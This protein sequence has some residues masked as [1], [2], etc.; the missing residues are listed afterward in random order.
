MNKEWLWKMQMDAIESRQIDSDACRLL[1]LLCKRHHRNICSQFPEPFQLSLAQASHLLG[2]SK[3][4]KTDTIQQLIDAEY[5]VKRG[6]TGCPPTNTYMIVDWGATTPI[7]RGQSTPINKGQSA[8]INQGHST[9]L[10]KSISF[11]EEIEPNGSNSA[12]GGSNGSLRSKETAE[13]LNG[14]TK[15]TNRQ[16]QA[17]AAELASLRST[18]KATQ[19][20]ELRRRADD[21]PV[22]GKAFK[23]VKK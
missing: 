7:K 3:T 11:Q 2:Y 15:L 5:I 16:R 19:A 22:N 21:A 12:N 13:G 14:E 23:M 9:P 8:P 20:A 1:L 10:H 17:M 4:T 18:L 6:V